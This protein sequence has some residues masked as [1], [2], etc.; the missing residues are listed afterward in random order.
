MNAKH[1]ISA[2]TA[3]LN[4]QAEYISDNEIIINR[5][6]ILIEGNLIKTRKS[7][8][9][10]PGIRNFILE[11]VETGILNS[12]AVKAQNHIL[13]HYSHLHNEKFNIKKQENEN[14]KAK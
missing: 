4:I 1:L 12:S 7:S 13:A 6:R 14:R 2:L 10:L 5:E 11:L 9:R 3:H 8:F